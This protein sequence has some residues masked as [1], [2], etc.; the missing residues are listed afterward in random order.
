MDRAGVEESYLLGHSEREL[1]RLIR[2]SQ[3][4]SDMTR[5]V[6]KMA[7]I[8]PG[9][10]VLDVGCGAGDVSFITSDLVGADGRVVGFD[11]SP[12]A[13]AIAN[14]R[15]EDSSL[16]GVEFHV[17][18]MESYSA[19]HDFDAVIGRFILLHLRE[20]AKAIARI[21]QNVKPGTTIAFC[22]IDLG[23]TSASRDMPLLK[24]CLDRI[25]AVYKAM[26]FEPDMGS[27]L[28]NTFRVAGLAPKLF[29][30]TRVADGNDASAFDFLAESV[31]SLLPAMEKVGVATAAEVG[32]DTLSDRLAAEAAAADAC[33]FFPRFVG[34]WA[35]T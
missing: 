23:T 26:G 9:M 32:I 21:A 31:R 14:K 28:H 18:T 17:G 11:L 30:F 8:E 2:Q 1:A 20:P 16:A 24:G 12:G 19:Y 5:Q 3:F 4:F 27:K 33:I 35:R 29:G 15:A 25:V 10:R 13:I 7:G 6:L 22:E 34:A